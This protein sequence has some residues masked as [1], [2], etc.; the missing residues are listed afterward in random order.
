VPTAVPT[1]A[2]TATAVPTP[3]PAPTATPTPVPTPIPTAPPALKTFYVSPTGNDANPGTQAAPWRSFHT[4]LTRLRPGDMLYV[5]GGSYSFSGI[6]Y[7][8][9]AGTATS[10]IVIT[11]YPGETPVFTGTST[12]ADFLYFSGS[13]AWVTLRGLTVQGGGVTTDSNGS[14]LLGFIDGASHIRI[15]NMTLNGSAGWSAQQH[16][17]YIAASNVTDIRFTG[18]VFDGGGCA[19]A[20]LLQFYHD[21]NAATVVVSGN[22]FRR[23]DQ[24]LLV[25]ASASGVQVTS[26]AFSDL[27]IAVRHHNSGGT[28]V[29]GNTGTNVGTGVYADS[30][31]NLSVS[32]NSW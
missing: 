27:R 13:S 32:G 8:T 23:A 22:T 19:C 31:V 29:T 20:G 18:N 17:A 7:T 12:P 16:L 4:S 28:S 24:G 21:P 9:L 25:W 26:N 11:A 2:P 3:T 1:P 14:S 5:R 10:P 15:E 6:N 30:T